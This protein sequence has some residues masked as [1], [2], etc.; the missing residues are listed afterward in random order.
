MLRDSKLI[1]PRFDF[2]SATFANYSNPDFP[3]KNENVLTSSSSHFGAFFHSF[4]GHK[5][6]PRLK[7]FSSIQLTQN[8][9]IIWDFSFS[10]PRLSLDWIREKKNYVQCRWQKKGT[11]KTYHLGPRHIHLV[12][13]LARYHEENLFICFLNEE[14]L[15][16][17]SR[18]LLSDNFLSCVFF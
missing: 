9:L 8:T 17:L 15:K 2:Y 13:F 18:A 1:I 3:M 14:S 10:L 5:K 4:K 11:K 12:N 16:S 6:F 7:I